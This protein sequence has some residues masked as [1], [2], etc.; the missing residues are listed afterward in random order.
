MRIFGAHNTK[1]RIKGASKLKH[2]KAILLAKNGG[3]YMLMKAFLSLIFAVSCFGLTLNYDTFEAN[4]VQT[5]KNKS[6]KKIEYVGKLTAKKPS[7]ALW[8][9]TKPVKKSVYIKNDSVIVYEPE[10]SQAKYLKKKGNISLDS[11]LKNA[12]AEGTNEYSAKDG[13][14]TYYFKVSDGM[15][16]KL[17]YKDSL[18]NDTEIIFK[19]RKKNMSVKSDLFD[20]KPTP[21]IDIIR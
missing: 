17:H 2:S 3:L 7:L 18:E 19:D 21:D 15:I 20:F 12:K 11:I 8:Q 4:F 13:D 5:I 10:L 16:E 9:Y 1:T 6:G 14:I